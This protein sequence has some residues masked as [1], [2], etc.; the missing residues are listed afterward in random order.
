[1]LV[2]EKPGE[3][4]CQTQPRRR[5]GQ[6]GGREAELVVPT[7]PAFPWPA[8]LSSPIFRRCVKWWD[9]ATRFYK[10]PEGQK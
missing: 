10:I 5:A 2:K 1:M 9:M 8:S 6:G 7:P 4:P 3:R